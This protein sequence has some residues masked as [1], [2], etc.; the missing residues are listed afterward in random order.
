MEKIKFVDLKKEREYF[1]NSVDTRLKTVLESGNYLFS[2]Q[3]KE[4][5]DKFPRYI[6]KKNGYSVK[7]CTDAIMIL[8]KELWTEDLPIIL[9]NFGAYPTSIAARNFSQN[10]FYVD[11]DDTMTIDPKKLPDRVKNGILIA[12]NLFGNNCDFEAIREY[13]KRNNHIFIEDCAQSTGSGSGRAGD[14]SVFS[15]YP[16]KPL[17]CYGDGGFICSDHDL[18]F[19]KRLRFYGQEGNKIVDVGVNSR[20]DEMQTSIILAK[21]PYFEGLNR[22]RRK[23]AERYMKIVRGITW[24][25]G[26]VFHQF[27]ILFRDR[28]EVINLMNERNIESLIHYPFHVSEIPV[29]M[30]KENH[31]G[32][33]VSDNILSIPIHPF[34]T[35]EEIQRIEEFLYD[36]REEEMAL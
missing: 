26:A 20:I 4:L 30:G 23:I 31:V 6:G 11:V 7:N 28:D 12:V 13:C 16:T 5:E 2:D 1:K 29:L 19:V 9:P 15:F 14:F 21:F 25:D 24:R 34:L 32:Y 17:A 3:T 33:R 18:E 36:V 8:L 35:E 27:P 22:K 10:L